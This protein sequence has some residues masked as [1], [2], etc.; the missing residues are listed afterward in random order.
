MVPGNELLYDE[1]NQRLNLLW[2]FH[3]ETNLPISKGKFSQK[4]VF[5]FDF[6]IEKEGKLN[7]KKK[8]FWHIL[9]KIVE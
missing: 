5:S 8:N 6:L 7:S 3:F 4:N 9:I 1:L 2:F